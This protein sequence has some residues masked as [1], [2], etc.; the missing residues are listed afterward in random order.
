MPTLFT[1]GDLT[2][3][4]AFDGI[5]QQQ[6]SYAIREYRIEPRQ[7]AGIIRLFSED[8]IPTIL[9]ALRRTAGAATRRSVFA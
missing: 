1:I 8:Q 4:A 3:R 5:R 9:A 6:I 7:R 2:R